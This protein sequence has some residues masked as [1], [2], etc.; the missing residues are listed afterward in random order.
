[1]RLRSGLRMGILIV[2][3]ML[4]VSI[5]AGCGA[6]R[7]ASNDAGASAKTSYSMA[8]SPADHSMN[9]EVVMVTSGGSSPASAVADQYRVESDTSEQLTTQPQLAEPANTA[10]EALDRKLIYRAQVTMEVADYGQGQTELFNLVTMSRGY[11]LNFSDNESRYELGGVFVIKVPSNGF[12]SFLTQLE[13]LKKDETFQ[14]NVQGQD[15]TEEYVDLTSRLKAKQVVEQ[16]LLGFMEKATDTKNLLDFSNQLA[17]VQEEIETIKGRMRYIDSNVSYSTIELRMYQ[18]LEKKEPK[19]EE[20]RNAF[21]RAGEAMKGS[22]EAIVSFF[23][24]LLIV[25]AGAF[26]ILIVLAI[27]AIPLRIGYRIWMGN[28]KTR[29][30]HEQQLKDSYPNL[31]GS[32][33]TKIN[34]DEGSE[35]SPDEEKNK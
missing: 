26:P 2:A 20:N 33:S 13:K 14:R 28:R 1:M 17:K 27:L 30:G 6:A 3:F 10:L 23:E 19:K 11:M 21:L 12:Q 25:L 24:G 5:L 31:S 34:T 8:E 35:H 7:E 22:A 4:L 29:N 15:V 16:R 32:Y 18:T 9:N